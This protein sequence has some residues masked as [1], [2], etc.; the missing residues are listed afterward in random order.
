MGNLLK[1]KKSWGQLKRILSREGEDKRISGT[2][3][4]AVVQQVLL[5][6]AD[7]LV[8]TTQ[9]ERALDSFM[10]GFVIRITGRHPQR[11]WEGKW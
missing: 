10:H 1:A 6:G 9:I 5:F 2:F 3:S 8:M 4:K 11:G 7:M